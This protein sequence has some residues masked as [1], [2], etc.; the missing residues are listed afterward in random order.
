MKELIIGI[1][2][3]A[4]VIFIVLGLTGEEWGFRSIKGSLKGALK[5]FLEFFK[6]EGDGG[7]GDWP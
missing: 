6:G 7:I 3:A 5:E 1:F 2:V 4:F